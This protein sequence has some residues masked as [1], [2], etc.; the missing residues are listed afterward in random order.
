MA[1]EVRPPRTLMAL[2]YRKGDMQ[3]EPRPAIVTRINKFGVASL[4]AFA[5]NAVIPDIIDGARHH[6]DPYVEDHLAA[7]QED[8]RGTWDYV[9]VEKDFMDKANSKLQAAREAEEKKQRAEQVERSKP[10]Q[11]VQAM[12]ELD[13]DALSVDE[14]IV[15]ARTAGYNAVQIAV[16]LTKKTDEQWNHQK[17][18]ARQRELIKE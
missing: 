8:G 1:Y 14:I 10:P 17:V 13:L 15:Q 18:N 12:P 11:P 6:A 9:E 3:S 7:V 16:V 2:W 4:T 5:P